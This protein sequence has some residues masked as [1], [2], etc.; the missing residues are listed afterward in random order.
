MFEYQSIE[1]CHLSCFRATELF[2]QILFFF[3]ILPFVLHVRYRDPRYPIF[4][5]AMT[6][7]IF[8]RLPSSAA[9]ISQTSFYVN[10]RMST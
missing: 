6:R 5:C 8:F 7:C 3:L 1:A 4:R 10:Q 9:F 2:P